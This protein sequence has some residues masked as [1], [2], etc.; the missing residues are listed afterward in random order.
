MVVVE[1]SLTRK[2]SYSINQLTNPVGSYFFSSFL[3]IVLLN[4]KMPSKITCLYIFISQLF[5]P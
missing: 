2:Y 4:T 5:G 1:N 3:D